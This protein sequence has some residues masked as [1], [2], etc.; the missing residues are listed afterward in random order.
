MARFLGAAFVVVLAVAAGG[1]VRAADDADVKALLDKGIKALGGEE[2]LTAA[3]AVTWKSKGTIRFGDNDSAFS[4][5][6]SVQGLDHFRQ[7][8]EADFGGNKVQGVVVLNGD[9]GW[10]KFGDMKMEMDAKAL[11]NQKRGVYLMLVP[12]TLVPLREKGFKVTAAGEEKV[13]GKP[14]VALKV[15]P[16]DGKEF[17]L[18]LDKESG[19]PVKQAAKVDDFMGQEFTQE[20]TFGGYKDLGGIKKATKIENK[21]DG[22]KFMEYEI[23][24]FKLLDKLDSKTFAEPE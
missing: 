9:K 3:K 15:T 16:P 21:R 12:T 19:L 6:G 10:R 5:A 1:R 4:S 22:E 11:A 24:E 14:A 20:T 18:Y 17:T 7:E 23:T 2:K 13:A 8:F